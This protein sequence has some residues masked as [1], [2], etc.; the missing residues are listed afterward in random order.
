MGTTYSRSLRFDNYVRMQNFVRRST[1]TPF[2]RFWCDVNL[3]REFILRLHA[4]LHGTL[5]SFLR[6][7]LHEGSAEDVACFHAPQA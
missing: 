5:G 4:T 7:A 6:D 1:S 2:R 3:W